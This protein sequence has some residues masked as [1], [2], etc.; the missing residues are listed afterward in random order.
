MI[1]TV[2]KKGVIVVSVLRQLGILFAVCLAGEGISRLLPFAFPA[3][4]VAMVLLLILL[5][6]GVLKPNRMEPCG[7]FLLDHMALFFVPS[8]V[9][10]LKYWQVLLQNL[11]PIVIICLLTTP[12]VFFV[13]GHAVQL[14]VRLMH[15]RKERAE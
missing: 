10:I 7:S 6:C 5:F 9:S 3:S 4:V 11:W 2:C 1:N 13:T 14:T 15:G 8:C 12:L